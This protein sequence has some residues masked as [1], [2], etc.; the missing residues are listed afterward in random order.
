MENSDADVWFFS[1]GYIVGVGV[2]SIVGLHSIHL[3]LALLAIAVTAR[4]ASDKLEAIEA[5]GREFVVMEDELKIKTRSARAWASAMLYTA[6]GGIFAC[7]AYYF[8]NKFV[9]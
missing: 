2:L 8:F 1:G 3:P 6:S 9:H 4:L 5:K 7:Q